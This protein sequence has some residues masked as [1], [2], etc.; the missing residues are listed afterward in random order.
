MS[1]T[2][3]FVGLFVRN[4]KDLTILVMAGVV[5]EGD[6]PEDGN[7]YFKPSMW[8]YVGGPIHDRTVAWG[9]LRLMRKV[10]LVLR[11]AKLTCS[12]WTVGKLSHVDLLLVKLPCV[13]N[14]NFHD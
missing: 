4:G 1:G 7:L 13:A 6:F 2:S 10:N 5:E 9:T 14:D 12:G 11:R 3:N 8:A